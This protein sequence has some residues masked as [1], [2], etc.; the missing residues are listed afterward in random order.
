MSGKRTRAPAR[1]KAPA[2]AG[3]A[4]IVQALAEGARYIDSRRGRILVGRFVH[5]LDR[6]DIEIAYRDRIFFDPIEV[7]QAEGNEGGRRS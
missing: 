3:E 7:D 4:A 2:S 5:E 6:V 1:V